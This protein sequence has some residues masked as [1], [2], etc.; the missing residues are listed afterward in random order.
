MLRHYDSIIPEKNHVENNNS[1][2][3]GIEQPTND[4][5]S[6][7]VEA[8]KVPQILGEYREIDKSFFNINFMI[9]FL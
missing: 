3:D 9:D 6:Q 4:N 1:D 5:S 8:E 7:Y 2:E